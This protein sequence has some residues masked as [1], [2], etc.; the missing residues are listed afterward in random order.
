MG[1]LIDTNVLSEL[2]KGDKA[3]VGVQDWFANTDSKQLYISVLTLGEIRQ[4]IEQLK[5]RDLIASQVLEHWLQ[6][7]ETASARLILP[8]SG[9]IADHW[10]RINVPD[11]MPIIDGY[12][13]LIN[14]RL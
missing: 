11:K 2:R 14:K 6:Q 10:G 3:N 5:R 7:I 12:W 9:E 1:Y 13:V 4:G 8:V